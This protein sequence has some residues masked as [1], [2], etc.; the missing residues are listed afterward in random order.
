MTNFLHSIRSKLFNF[1]QKQKKRI[2]MTH[3]VLSYSYNNNHIGHANK[4]M[5][6]KLHHLKWCT[7][8]IQN[9]WI[10]DTFFPLFFTIDIQKNVSFKVST[11][12]NVHRHWWHEWCFCIFH[13]NFRIKSCSKVERKIDEFFDIFFVFEPLKVYIYFLKISYW[14][15]N[16]NQNDIF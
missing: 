8:Y 1:R 2:T 7:M 13:Q 3:S 15:G 9:E 10:Y 12:S 11:L 14:N 6:K 5:R 4:M 16:S